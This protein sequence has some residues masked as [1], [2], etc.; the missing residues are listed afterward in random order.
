[1]LTLTEIGERARQVEPA[2]RNMGVE[3]KTED[4][5]ELPNFWWK[6]AAIF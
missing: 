4:W 1:M 5:S 6:R 3:Q 2:L